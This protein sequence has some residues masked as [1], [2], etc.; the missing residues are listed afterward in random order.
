MT[1]EI[2]RALEVIRDEC[3]K[4]ECCN[5]DCQLYNTKYTRFNGEEIC[6]LEFCM[7]FEYRIEAWEKEKSNG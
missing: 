3:R 5:Q 4:H 7:P 6:L 1:P 2:K